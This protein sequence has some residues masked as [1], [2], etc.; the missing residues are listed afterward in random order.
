MKCPVC[1]AAELIHDTR[2]ISYIYKGER[3]VISAVTGEHCPDCT[4]SVLGPEESSRVMNEMLAFK[5]QVNAATVDPRFIENTRR[6][7]SLDQ[8]EAAELFGGG[9]NAFSRYES[10]K[11]KPPLALVQLFKLL[12]NH[13]NL[14]SELKP[15]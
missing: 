4:E 15:A 5:K 3:T 8:R 10:G 2:D 1:G 12:E 13:P 11:T 6:K 7:L 14:L 9:V